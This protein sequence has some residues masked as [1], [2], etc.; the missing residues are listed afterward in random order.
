MAKK[1]ASEE[2]AKQ[3]K[4]TLLQPDARHGVSDVI[5]VELCRELLTHGH[6][7]SV[8]EH[9]LTVKAG[10]GESD[11]GLHAIWKLLEIIPR[12]ANRLG[13][14]VPRIQHRMSEDKSWLG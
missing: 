13:I 10:I 9:V 1:I 2:R 7:F 6:A 8:D 3:V 4:I 12:W 5:V 11:E 14:N